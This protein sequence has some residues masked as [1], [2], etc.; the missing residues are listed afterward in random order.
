[1]Y[2]HEFTP[3]ERKKY[4]S[5]MPWNE[6]SLPLMA[7]GKLRD[8]CSY[9]VAFCPNGAFLIIKNAGIDIGLCL[10]V[11]FPTQLCAKA[12]AKGMGLP[13]SIEDFVALGFARP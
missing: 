9:F 6:G 5:F 4:P 10:Q 3:A 7:R 12:L 8:G 11:K 13:G 1:M 2:T